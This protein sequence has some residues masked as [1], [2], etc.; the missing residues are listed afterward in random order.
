M[1][2]FMLRQMAS[3]NLQFTTKKISDLFKNPKLLWIQF[4]LY[5]QNSLQVLFPVLSTLQLVGYS[6]FTNVSTELASQ[7]GVFSSTSWTL[8]TRP[9]CL[10]P[11]C[12]LLRSAAQMFASLASTNS[13]I[14]SVISLFG[15]TKH[16]VYACKSTLCW[17]VIAFTE[18]SVCYL[19][20]CFFCYMLNFLKKFVL[21]EI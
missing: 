13:A 7:P 10:K 3:A 15:F 18:L 19:S 12:L 4:L 14:L 5:V 17:S 1:I 21:I 16:F 2:Q 11:F 20:S 9:Q 8:P 6:H